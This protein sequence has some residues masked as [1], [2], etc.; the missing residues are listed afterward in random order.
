VGGQVRVQVIVDQGGARFQ[1]LFQIDHRIQGLE[2]GPDIL[3]RVLGDVAAF[4]KD[5]DQGLAGMAYLVPHQGNG[6]A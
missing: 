1:G 4:G 2:F 6:G 3:D 5:H